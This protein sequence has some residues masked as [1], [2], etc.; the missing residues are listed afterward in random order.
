MVHTVLSLR[1]EI[2]V[3]AV[4]YFVCVRSRL[5]AL[6]YVLCNVAVD[7]VLAYQTRVVVILERGNDYHF[8]DRILNANFILRSTIIL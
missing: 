7:R 2:G 1:A 4:R 3:P 8:V 6:M 5:S